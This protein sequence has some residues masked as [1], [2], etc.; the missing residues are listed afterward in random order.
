PRFVL[1]SGDIGRIVIARKTEGPAKGKWLFTA[2]TVERI[3]PMFLAV[4]GKPVDE[5]LRGAMPPGH[6]PALRETP[7]IW[8][9]LRMPQWARIAVGGLE[10]YQWCGLVL[11][12]MLSWL[13]AKLLLTS[14]ELVGISVLRRSGSALTGSYVMSKL[15]PLTW[16]VTCWLFF[17]FPVWL[18]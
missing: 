4:L 15:R 16:L 13:V 9:R 8:L 17:K 12:L 14:L 10:L 2:E 11:A 7:G 18:D 1:H 6:P 5:S 3:E